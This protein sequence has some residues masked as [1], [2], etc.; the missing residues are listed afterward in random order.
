M[1][2]LPLLL[3]A[4][5]AL[6]HL[7][8]QEAFHSPFR[9]GSYTRLGINNMSAV[10][11]QSLTPKQNMV[12][13]NFG[14]DM[15]FVFEKGRIFYFM[16]KTQKSFINVGLDWTVISLTYN[17][18][19]KQWANYAAAEPEAVTSPLIATISTKLGPVI[20]INP[21]QDLVIDIRAQVAAI[22]G[23]VG[24]MYEGKT[25]AVVMAKDTAEKVMDLVKSM[26]NGLKP[27]IGATIRW[28]SIGL[29]AD[30]SPGKL[31]MNYNA[32][33]NGIETTGK[34]SVPF[35]TFQIKLSFTMKK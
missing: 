29:S 22:G 34:E 21:V 8:A 17:S 26:P 4:L 20:S 33:D 3:L 13:G 14:A 28:R 30:Y 27:N 10:L 11:N 1:K 7:Q 35:N 9:K 6:S 32:K 18:N 15:G 12:A 2:K 31:K 5:T 25:H 23:V 16:P 24:P 19:K